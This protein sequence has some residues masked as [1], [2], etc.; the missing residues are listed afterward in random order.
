[1]KFSFKP[2]TILNELKLVAGSIGSANALPILANFLIKL[3]QS[4]ATI[5]ASDMETQMS[6]IVAVDIDKPG[7]I[8]LP[9]KKFVEICNAVPAD[10]VMTVTV[11]NERAI[12]QSGRSRFALSTLPAEHFTG[13]DHINDALTFNLPAENLRNALERVSH[14]M[15]ENDVRY[16]LN[17]MLFEIKQTG[18]RCVA[19]DGHRLAMGEIAVQINSDEVEQVVVP[20]KSIGLISKAIS[21]AAEVSVSIEKSKISIN[22]GKVC[23]VSQLIEGN[24]PHYEK[25]IPKTNK[26]LVIDRH[27]LIAALQRANILTSKRF[28]AARL[29]LVDSLLRI[30]VMNDQGEQSHEELTIDFKGSIELGM[31]V[32]YLIDALSGCTTREVCL[33]LSEQNK[34]VVVQNNNDDSAYRSVVMPTRL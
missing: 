22:T 16:Y 17:G 4:K 1:M 18:L 19:T 33:A 21:L 26:K 10:S 2:K 28:C 13:M 9:A 25:V 23:L 32:G 3:E 12:L 29:V 30:E 27:V 20:R 24:Y 7:A 11:K 5:T 8:T 14:A 6:V 31:N 15:A 34:G